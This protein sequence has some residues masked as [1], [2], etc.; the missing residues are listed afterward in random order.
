VTG[1]IGAYLHVDFN[2]AGQGAFIL[3]RF[4]RG[5]PVLAPQLYAN[6]GALGLIV[7]LD[8]KEE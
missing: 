5:A 7:L 6:M 2:R 4:I 1:L 8:P 3:E